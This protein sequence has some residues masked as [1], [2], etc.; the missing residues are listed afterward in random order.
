MSVLYHFVF[1]LGCGVHLLVPRYIYKVVED[2]AHHCSHSDTFPLALGNMAS[3]S[4]QPATPAP[5]YQIELPAA[6]AIAA[7]AESSQS[8]DAYLIG[9][10]PLTLAG[11]NISQEYTKRRQAE[12]EVEK[13][14][15]QDR[16]L[17]HKDRMAKVKKAGT[18]YKEKMA[19]F[20]VEGKKAV[21][22]RD[23]P[24]TLP[25][26]SSQLREGLRVRAT[27]LRRDRLLYWQEVKECK[28]EEV[29]IQQDE[30]RVNEMFHHW[31]W[32]RFELHLLGID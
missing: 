26:V 25:H 31:E 30:E 9:F 3:P 15:I 18:A 17:I 16:K 7:S 13:A 21:T 29:A 27:Q 24:A 5:P 12:L 22:L 6:T 32:A 19:D 28:D 10:P 11:A 23:D 14:Q 4:Q 1:R 2:A 8:W 20:E